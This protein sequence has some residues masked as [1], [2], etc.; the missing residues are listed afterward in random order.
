MPV[1]KLQLRPGLV[2]DTTSYANE[3][4]WYYSDKVRFSNGYPEKIGGWVRL[5]TSPYLGTC[6]ALLPWASLSGV[7]YTAVGTNIKYYVEYGSALTDI[8]PIRKTTNPLANDPI[9]TASGTTTLTIADTAHGA[10]MG[11]YVTI[12]GATGPINGIPASEIN[13]EHTVVLVVDDDSYTI[14]VA[15]TASGSGVGGGAAVVAAYQ[16]NV[17]LDIFV[18]GTGWSAGAWGGVAWGGSSSLTNA[19]QLRLWSQSTFGEDLVF[20]ERGGSIFYWDTSAGLTARAVYLQDMP[21]AADV[22]TVSNTIVVTHSRHV[23]AFGCNPYDSPPDLVQDPLLVRWSDAE[24]AVN[25]TPTV[26]NA[27]GGFRLSLGSSILTAR[28]TRMETLIWT[29]AALYS[30]TFIGGSL[31][32]GF[33]LLGTPISL[34]SPGAVGVVGGTAYWMGRDKFYMYNGTVNTLPCPLLKVIIDNLNHSQSYQIFAATNEQYTEITWY[35][36]SPNSSVVDSYLTYNYGENV[37]YF[38][39]L[40]RSA[41]AD[42]GILQFPVAADNVNK[43]LVNHEIGTD[44]LS[45]DSTAAISAYIES[46]DFDLGDGHQ[47]MFINK[48]I[49]DVSFVGSSAINPSLLLT[50]KTRNSPG[51][52]WINSDTEPS[53]SAVTRTSSEGISTSPIEQFTPQAWVRL[54]GRQAAVR[55]SS[56][57]IGVAW[58]LGALRLDLRPDGRR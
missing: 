52:T 15:S 20:C 4:G 12:S 10:L 51:N 3:G 46:S 37:W 53:D 11:D 14:S 9:T 45:T 29:D 22:P 56:D 35:Y 50:L 27:A 24:S 44:D 23:V 2:R 58:Q 19:S 40:G 8:T 1:T 21:G 48:V 39:T 43:V 30:M 31:V 54:R 6:T 16:I 57:A 49:P 34:V 33:N 26:V 13:A 25:W 36:C 32:F 17:G 47:F 42:S 28:N 18:A 55:I 41:W 5:T 7:S 38:G